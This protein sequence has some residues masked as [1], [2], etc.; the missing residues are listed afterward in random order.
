[1]AETV[2]LMFSYFEHDWDESLEGAEA[3]DA[4]LMRRVTEGEWTPY[5]G[6]EPDPEDIATIEELEARAR[7]AVDEWDVPDDVVRVPIEKLRAVID[8]GGW[9]FVAG[10]FSEFEGHHNDTEYVVKL[11]RQPAA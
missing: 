9:T 4:E 8:G 5:S 7:E 3:M 1:M 10:E 2:M 11:T 6:D